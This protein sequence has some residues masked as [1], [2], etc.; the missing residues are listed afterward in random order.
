MSK[1]S[2]HECA[3]L[4]VKP[5]ILTD[6]LHELTVIVFFGR[7]AIWISEALRFPRLAASEILISG[8]IVGDL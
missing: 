1:V 5:G 2:G 4:V 7:G 8:G 6:R 3:S